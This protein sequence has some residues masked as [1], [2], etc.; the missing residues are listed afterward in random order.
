[1]EEKTRTESP[2]YDAAV[3]GV[4]GTVLLIVGLGTPL[5]LIPAV[6]FLVLG[7]RAAWSTS[8]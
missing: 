6:V 3:Y 2:R 8:R 1:M 5:L 4:I 7:I